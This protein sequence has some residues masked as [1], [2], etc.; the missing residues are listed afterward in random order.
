M[1]TEV[2]FAGFGGQGVLTAG[3]FL[4]QA[5]M[6]E[7]KEVCWMPSYGPEMRG[8]TANCTVVLS[9]RRIGSPIIA[10]PKVAVAMN[11]PSLDKFES[12]VVPG[13]LVII[14]SSLIERDAERD[15]V[16]V[17]KVPANQMAIDLG[18]AKVANI[19]ILGA[20]LG[21]MPLVDLETI[22]G[23]IQKT[24]GKKK[25]QLVET[26]YKALQQGYE[27]GQDGGGKA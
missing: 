4:A 2:I 26:N 20:L 8:G 7:G 1:Q 21:R 9:E 25:P 27:L 24:F 23:L 13:G 12:A 17:L 18:S 15:D 6:D 16:D 22:R 3:K 19:I 5:G 14:N 11:L 10:H